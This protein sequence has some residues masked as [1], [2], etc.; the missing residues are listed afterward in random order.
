MSKDRN[1]DLNQTS[2]SSSSSVGHLPLVL[3]I[4]PIFSQPILPPSL[5]DA[6]I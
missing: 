6:K 2:S 4:E 3:G 1:K 5:E